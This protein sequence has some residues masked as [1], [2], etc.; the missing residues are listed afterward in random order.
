MTKLRDCEQQPV[1]VSFC[2]TDGS[3][4]LR[5]NVRS[6]T[7][8]RGGSSGDQLAGEFFQNQGSEITN[9]DKAFMLII[10]FMIGLLIG[11]VVIWRDAELFRRASLVGASIS[12]TEITVVPG[13]SVWSLAQKYQLPEMTQAETVAW[14]NS[15]NSLKSDVLKPGQILLV[16]AR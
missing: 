4:A 1:L 5:P 8:V 15:T 11:G 6:F 14:I 9:R 3:S 13:D 12:T 2:S 16:P 10:T 7:I